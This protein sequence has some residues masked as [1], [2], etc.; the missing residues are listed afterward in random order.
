LLHSQLVCGNIENTTKMM[1]QALEKVVVSWWFHF[2]VALGDF[3]GKATFTFF[4]QLIIH[5]HY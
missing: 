3:V 2:I 1:E 5:K 4:K